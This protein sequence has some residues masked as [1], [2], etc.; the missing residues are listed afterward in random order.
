MANGNAAI[1]AY[2]RTATP[3]PP[4]Q[5]APWYVN[6]AP[7]YAG[8][9]LWIA[10][11]DQLGEAFRYGGLWAVLIGAVFAGAACHLLFYY[12]P[13]LL[14]M[15]TG[16]PLY[17]VGTSTFGARGGFLIPGIFMGLLQI[18]WYS[19][20]TYYSTKL[21]LNGFGLPAI[22]P[23]GLPEDP[24]T[25]PQLPP[26][27][28]AP[29]FDPLFIGMALVWGYAFALIGGL[30]I[31][32]VA[33]VAQFFPIV[34]ILLLLI[35]SVQALLYGNFDGFR[36]TQQQAGVDVIDPINLA[37]LFVIQMV[38]GFFGTAGAVGADFCSNNRNED[39]VKWGGVFGIWLAV[40][41]TAGLALITVAGAFGSAGGEFGKMSLRYGDAL[42][43][44]NTSNGQPNWLA[45]TMLILFAVGSMAPA[46]FCSFIIGNSL[47]TMLARPQAR[48]PITL[49]GATVGILIAMTGASAQLAPYFG[50]IGASFGPVIGAMI[51]DFALSGGTWSGP[52]EG[53]NWAGYGA[54]L[55]GFLVGI[56]NNDMV[57]TLLGI[58]VK[59]TDTW[60]H[61]WRAHPT[62]VYS[63]LTGAIVYY[64][65]ARI[66]GLPA[67]LPWSP[68]SSDTAR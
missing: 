67:R 1:P 62:G 28:L 57:G 39:D 66:L 65:L 20:A 18:G 27:Q 49:A 50:L 43:K 37:T 58:D 34:P 26:E 44:L 16:L 17:I 46:C 21:I 47:S 12:V 36:Q 4:D 10:F 60:W 61:T 7:S 64:L 52:R 24:K 30:G 15:Q 42:E 38:V 68:G 48:L 9:F 31:Q 33:R 3:V 40:I 2:L 13:G 59:A 54:W 45:K 63:L 32:Y 8:I 56:S 6:T 29:Q 11:Y 23:Y 5:R 14:G 19:V 22:T 41:F 35:G 53:V 51:A 25:F 55:V